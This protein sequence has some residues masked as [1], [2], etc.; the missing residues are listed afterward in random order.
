MKN[1][2]EH[3][4]ALKKQIAGFVEG[5]GKAKLKITMAQRKAKIE[6]ANA[7]AVD[8]MEGQNIDIDKDI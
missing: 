1:D 2:P 8:K 7:W 6:E 3:I 5:L 4:S